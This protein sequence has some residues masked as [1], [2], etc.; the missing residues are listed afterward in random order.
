MAADVRIRVVSWNL[1][2]TTPGDLD[3]K[4]ELLRK[5]NP[6]F[7]LLQ[8]ISRPVYRSLLPNP[9]VHQRL[10]ERPRLFSWGTLSTD[11]TMTPGSDQQLGCAVLGTQNT[12]LLTAEL[13]SGSV[14]DDDHP[15]RHGML[16]RTIAAQVALPGAATVTLCSAQARPNPKDP[17]VRVPPAFHAAIAQWLASTAWPII[18][19]IEAQAPE[20]DHPNPRRS[21]FRNSTPEG[22]GPGE[23]QLLGAD[24][25]HGLVDVLR[26]HLRH[27][28]DEFAWIIAQRPEGP[29]AVSHQ[30]AGYPARHDHIWATPDLD[31]LDVRY[32]YREAV[33]TGGDH[34]LV[35]ADLS[36]STNPG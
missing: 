26:Q 12:M 18:I 19:G 35:M 2:S 14:F 27:R 24:A 23:D 22:G 7:A 10:Y 15:S 9:V 17:R 5:V 3:S 28:P 32:L 6:D 36:L 20:I 33:S 1:T 31:V 30:I 21:V 8:G 29:L 34:A 4:V 25:T 11:L 16:R 13:L